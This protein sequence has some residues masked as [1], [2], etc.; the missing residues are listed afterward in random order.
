MQTENKILR[1]EQILGSRAELLMLKALSSVPLPADPAFRIVRS[2]TGLKLIVRH[3]DSQLLHQQLEALCVQLSKVLASL[4]AVTLNERMQVSLQKLWRKLLISRMPSVLKDFGLRL[5]VTL[6]GVLQRRHR[7]LGMLQE[8]RTLLLSF[9]LREPEHSVR[10][11]L[12]RQLYYKLYFYARRVD[13]LAYGA[14]ADKTLFEWAEAESYQHCAGMYPE[15]RVLMTIH[16]GDF[17]GAFR[18]IAASVS[19]DRPVI[20]LRRDIDQL[21]P[22]NLRQL[23]DPVHTQYLHGQGNPVEIAQALRRGNQTLAVLFDLGRDF[24]ETT[25]VEFFS[26]RARFVR[27]PAQLAIAGRARIFPFVCFRCGSRNIIQMHAPFLPQARAGESLRQAAARVTQELVRL[28]E[29][30]IHERP[31]QWKYLDVLPGYFANE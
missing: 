30:W 10:K 24:G 21:D 13:Y 6:Y 23:D 3:T 17:I 27:G 26:H 5:V 9:L 28:A 29:Q 1:V 11:I 16:M 14:P 15:S 22:R 19:P 8:Q 7:E 4:P 12:Q 31:E 18:H 20:S 25:E 2:E